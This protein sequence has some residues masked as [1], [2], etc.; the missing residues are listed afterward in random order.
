[1]SWLMWIL[2]ILIVL[3]L[4]ILFKFK[5]IRHKIGLVIATVIILFLFV[6][7]Y[8]IY[9]THKEVDLKTFDGIVTA[10]KIYF[11][12][13]GN[14]FGNLFRI[15]GYVVNQDWGLNISNSSVK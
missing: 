7:V 11:G 6:S 10:G 3:V 9:N 1:M 13:L 8:Q 15:S 2:V 5:E 4:V 12:W 14:V